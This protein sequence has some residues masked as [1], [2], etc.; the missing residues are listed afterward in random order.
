[1]SDLHDALRDRVAAHTPDSVP[2][3]DVL[4]DRKRARDRRRHAVAAAALSA[5][6][7]AS[8]AVATA[9]SSGPS[10]RLPTV[11][12]PAS[13]PATGP[14]PNS[15]ERAAIRPPSESRMEALLIGTLNADPTT[16]C[17]WIDPRR[18]LMP[19]E[20]LLQAGDGYRVDFSTT[21]AAIRDGD[22]VLATV[23]EEVELGGGSIGREGD[24]VPGCPVSGPTWLGYF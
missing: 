7:V 19:I 15:V 24:G 12:G 13:P 17:L 4:Q 5:V 11:A 9:W 20:V 2:P 8:L 1:M 23:G 21:P 3:F 16:G 14:W 6:A 10:D 22:T 18:G